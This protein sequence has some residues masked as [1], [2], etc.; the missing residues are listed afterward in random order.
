MGADRPEDYS[1][2][3][4]P[5]PYEE[6][7]RGPEARQ[8]HRGWLRCGN[9]AYDDSSGRVQV[10][11]NSGLTVRHVKGNYLSNASLIPRQSRGLY[12]GEPLKAAEIGP[13]ARLRRMRR[14]KTPP[15]PSSALLRRCCIPY[16]IE[17]R[18]QPLQSRSASRA[19]RRQSKLPEMSNCYC[20]PG[21]AGGT[22]NGLVDP[23]GVETQR[24]LFP[25]P[26]ACRCKGRF[27]RYDQV[28]QQPFRKYLNDHHRSLSSPTSKTQH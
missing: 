5:P 11:E 21:R 23:G 20:H 28:R 25:Y 27:D 24:I 8:H 13:L 22:P 3:P 14:A 15:T 19:A 2:S 1:V 4:A 7:R 9:R 17:L 12:R 16:Q 18:S 6:Q 10:A 26:K